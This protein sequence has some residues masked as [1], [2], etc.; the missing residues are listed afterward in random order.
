[1]TAVYTS[2]LYACMHACM[3]MVYYLPSVGIGV[4]RRVQPQAYAW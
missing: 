3:H 4:T 1:M 2:I